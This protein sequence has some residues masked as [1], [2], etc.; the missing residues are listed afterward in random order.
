VD[1]RSEEHATKLL[2]TL[3]AYAKMA[4]E[5][6]HERAATLSLLIK[7]AGVDEEYKA[8]ALCHALTWSRASVEELLFIATG[9]LPYASLV[10]AVEMEAAHV[11]R[12]AWTPA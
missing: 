6:A 4:D 12:V 5:G 10:K 11:R 3:V 2:E 1:H 9:S 8:K 7:R